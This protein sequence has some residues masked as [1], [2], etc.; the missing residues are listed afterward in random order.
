[1]GQRSISGM[2][3]MLQCTWNMRRPV[4]Y[5]SLVLSAHKALMTSKMRL[6][7]MSE[8]MSEDA[9]DMRVEGEVGIQRRSL[10]LARQWG[11]FGE[12]S[13][14]RLGGY[15]QGLCSVVDFEALGFGKGRGKLKRNGTDSIILEDVDNGLVFKLGLS[16]GT[17]GLLLLGMHFVK[18]SC[19]DG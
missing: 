6:S 5:N 15:G 8:M 3:F 17:L 4:P 18:G 19:G 2:L 10:S 13:R 11:R 7:A 16:S 9:R 12:G 1:M 14:R